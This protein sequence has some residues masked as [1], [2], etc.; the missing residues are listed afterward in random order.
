MT[1]EGAKQV[2]EK[3]GRTTEQVMDAFKQINPQKRFVTA[4]EV[5]H[6]VQFLIENAAVNGQAITLDGGETV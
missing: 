6:A 3:T 5:A 4:Q 1:R 2:A